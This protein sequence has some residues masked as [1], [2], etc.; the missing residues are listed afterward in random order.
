MKVTIVCLLV[1]SISLAS[2][3]NLKNILQNR[4]ATAT[5]P[6]SSGMAGICVF[7]P[8]VNCLSNTECHGDKLC[9][10]EGCGS[11][12]KKPVYHHH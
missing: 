4:R 11:V 5:C 1:V 10:P 8:N 12:C 9:C 2:A 3:G 6:P 7:D